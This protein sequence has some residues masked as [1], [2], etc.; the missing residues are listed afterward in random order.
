MCG[1][2]NAGLM[3]RR[4]LGAPGAIPTV[5]FLLYHPGAVVKKMGVKSH[6]RAARRIAQIGKRSP[7]AHPTLAAT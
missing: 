7:I 2:G 3:E 4:V 6:D 5:D 1:S